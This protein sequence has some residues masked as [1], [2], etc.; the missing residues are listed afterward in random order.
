MVQRT[1]RVIRREWARYPYLADAALHH[2]WTADASGVTHDS[3]GNIVGAIIT[4]LWGQAH[5]LAVDSARVYAE[6]TAAIAGR[7]A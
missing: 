4:D 1:R 5:P 6:M 2:P 3:R 7:N